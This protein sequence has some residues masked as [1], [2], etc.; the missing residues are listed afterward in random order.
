M[1]PRFRSTCPGMMLPI[2]Q[3]YS[4]RPFHY[5]TVG[6]TY[7]RKKSVCTDGEVRD[8]TD[9]CFIGLL[10]LADEEEAK[11]TKGM[12]PKFYSPVHSPSI[13]LLYCCLPS[14]MLHA[15]HFFP[16][17][18]IQFGT[19]FFWHF[20][21]ALSKYPPLHCLSEPWQFSEA[22]RFPFILLRVEASLHLPATCTF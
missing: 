4:Q 16:H 19:S 13:S 20:T 2:V 14:V 15:R 12:L 21:S 22:T 9:N 3:L 6:H 18:A 11:K 7:G 1:D 10:K 17:F 8:K 5:I